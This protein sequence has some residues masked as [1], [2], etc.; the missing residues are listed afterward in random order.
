MV[1]A[2]DGFIVGGRKHPCAAVHPPSLTHT[3]TLCHTYVHDYAL[4]GATTQRYLRCAQLLAGWPPSRRVF[5]GD[6]AVVF[7]VQGTSD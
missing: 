2:G 3:H 6:N 1:A 7:T 4:G 5:T